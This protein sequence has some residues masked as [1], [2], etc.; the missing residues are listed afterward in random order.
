MLTDEKTLLAG[1][2]AKMIQQF[3]RFGL[4]KATYQELRHS[5]FVLLATINHFIDS[6]KGVK[7]SD[8]SSQLEITPGAVTHLINSLEE[9]GY[10]E[11]LTDPS[12]RR[13]V[14]VKLTQKG[15]S[16]CMLKEEKVLQFFVGLVD[17]MGEQDS[18]ELKRLLTSVY[19]YFK[20]RKK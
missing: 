10:V 3:K 15:N 2:L 5:E 7:V 8:L 11:R 20:E 13:I 6:D 1:E 18:R 19:T 4:D 16:I 14:L 12:D 9:A 17:Y